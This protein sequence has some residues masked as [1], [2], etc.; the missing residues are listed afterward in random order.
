M[1]MKGK[2]RYKKNAC[3]SL[4]IERRD[5]DGDDEDAPSQMSAGME[6]T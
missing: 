4:Q 3:L 1:K 5:G 6:E 2:E